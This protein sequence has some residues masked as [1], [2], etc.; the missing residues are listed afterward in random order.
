MC[1]RGFILEALRRVFNKTTTTVT[2]LLAS[3]TSCEGSHADI[4]FEASQHLD[5][6]ADV[7]GWNPDARQLGNLMLVEIAWGKL[8]HDF[9]ISFDAIVPFLKKLNLK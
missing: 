5:D 9:L 3:Q 8:H 2:E 4:E 6:T 1:H 7:L